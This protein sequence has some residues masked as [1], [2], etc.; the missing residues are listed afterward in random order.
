MVAIFVHF[1]ANRVGEIQIAT[2]PC[3]CQYVP[4]N[5]KQA[6]RR[7][8]SSWIHLVRLHARVRRVIHNMLNPKDR[9]NNKELQPEEIR[10]AEDKIAQRAQ[11]DPF[12]EEYEALERKKPI[13]HSI[14]LK[15]NPMLGEQGLIQIVV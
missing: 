3:Q 11:Q 15:L 14:L 12:R 5:Q 2:E 13:Q 10:D 6:G 8:N 4:T 9:Q 1:V 7:W